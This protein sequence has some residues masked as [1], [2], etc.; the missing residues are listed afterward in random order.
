MF[1]VNNETWDIALVAPEHPM[2]QRSDGSFTIGVCDDNKKV[3]FINDTLDNVLFKKVLCHELT[4]AAMFSYDV[5]LGI[6]EEEILAE[7]IATYGEE[8]I[9]ITN[10]LFERIRG[11]H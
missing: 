3:I 8:I 6:D 5:N 1:T 2:L 10:M 7:I 11:R 9:S 4:H